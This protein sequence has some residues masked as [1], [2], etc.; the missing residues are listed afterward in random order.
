MIPTPV[1]ALQE[2]FNHDP[3]IWRRSLVAETCSQDFGSAVEGS[4][5]RKREKVSSGLVLL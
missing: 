4:S 1:S 2:A 3:D 5:K